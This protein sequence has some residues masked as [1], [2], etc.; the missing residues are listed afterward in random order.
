[1]R[2]PPTMTMAIG[3]ARANAKRSSLAVS[4]VMP[5]VRLIRVSCPVSSLCA[6]Q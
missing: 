1:V 6:T 5:P 4:R 2:M 3:A